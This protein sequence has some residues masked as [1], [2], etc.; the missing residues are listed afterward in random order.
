MPGFAGLQRPIFA[1]DAY[2]DFCKIPQD[3]LRICGDREP[4]DLLNQQA[5]GWHLACDEFIAH[6]RDPLA[7]PELR[8]ALADRRSL[9]SSQSAYKPTTFKAESMAPSMPCRL[10]PKGTV[11][12]M[13]HGVPSNGSQRE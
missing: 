13:W 1:T 10:S 8:T 12:R 6:V 2:R 11:R 9:P 4:F 5:L 3:C 7:A